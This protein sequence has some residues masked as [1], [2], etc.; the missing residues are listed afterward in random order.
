MQSRID[1]LSRRGQ[2]QPKNDE[3]TQVFSGM[4][5][6]FR[7]ENQTIAF[8]SLTF[9]TPGAFIKLAG[10]YNLADDVMD[11]HGSLALQAKVSQTMTGWKRWVLKPADPFF[12][13]NG[14]GTFLRIRIDGSSQSPEFGIDHSKA[15]R[16]NTFEDS[17]R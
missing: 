4:T 10:T 15:E 16:P 5:G 3:I 14:A 1:S 2:G 8:R 13:K 9:A 7:L 12:A 17:A 11:F 6:N